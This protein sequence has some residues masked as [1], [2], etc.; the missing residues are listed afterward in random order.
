MKKNIFRFF[1][2]MLILL[3][4]VGCN[5]DNAEENDPEFYL[6]T[7]NFVLYVG[8]EKEIEYY[9]DYLDDYKLNI[10]IENEEI[11]KVE[12]DKVI[13][14][15]AGN[16]SFII[17]VDGYEDL[18][19]EARVRVIQEGSGFT[20]THDIVMTWVK[21]Q[22]QDEMFEAKLFPTKHPNYP[23]VT[24]SYES[25]NPDI[26]TERGLT[27]AADYD[28]VVTITIL[29]DYNGAVLSEEKEVTVV[30]SIPNNI[31]KEFLGQ[32]YSTITNDVSIDDFKT[33]YPNANIIFESGNKE[34]LSNTGKFTKPENDVYFNV[35]ATIEIPSADYSRVFVKNIKGQGM[36]VSEKA[37]IIKDDVLDKLGLSNYRITQDLALPLSEERFNATI[38]WSSPYPDVITPD[39]KVY[40]PLINTLVELRGTVS[41]GSGKSSFVLELE[42]LGK[43]SDNKWDDI[44][45]FL[46][47]YIFKEEI[48]TL[49]YSVMGVGPAYNAYNDGYVVF[50]EN[51]NIE[52][53]EDILPTTHN[54]RP[55]TKRSIQYVT[56]HDTANNQEGADAKM[57]N[58]FLK[59]S[60][61]TTSWHYTIDDKELYHHVPNDEIAWHAGDGGG[62]TGNR[63]SIGIE[64]CTHI[65]VDYDLVMRR[66]AKLVGQLLD[67]N[68]LTLYNVRQHNHW[69]GKNCPQVIRGS[70]RW[71]ELI[72]LIAIE[73]Y[74]R[75]HLSG[76][77]FVWE[78]LNP[79]VLDN[80]GKVVNHPGPATNVSYKV[81]VTYN[82]E[83]RVFE[84]TAL[85][86]AKK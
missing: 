80:T 33:K 76:V 68:D 9:V 84:H 78:S 13:A 2:F 15:K 28:E 55:L 65:G 46:D 56:I 1:I 40:Q 58:N 43:E 30:G 25:S 42:V 20:A 37:Q 18:F 26:L 19:A 67:E 86:Q 51:S 73:L 6:V 71:G 23:D 64:T 8:D 12:D 7:D 63:N 3:G 66:V 45:T 79:E 21:G 57:H 81:T 47:L 29:I 36:S 69:S 50:Y 16:S 62:G 5:P 85:L 61:T 83:T 14:L 53:I 32:F 75:Q 72:N 24:I 48:E 54:G 49:K 82:G 11:F 44:E 70:N 77:E 4:V 39:G 59:N 38:E 31:A 10:E 22:I 60:T 52:V 34:V 17:S 35:Y 41:I 74:G 27:Y